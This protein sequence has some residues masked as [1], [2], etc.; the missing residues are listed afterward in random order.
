MKNCDAKLL[1]EFLIII[2]RF[3][4]YTYICMIFQNPAS[5]ILCSPLLSPSSSILPPS[6][7]FSCLSSPLFILFIKKTNVIY[8]HPSPSSRRGAGGKVVL[9]KLR[10]IKNH[11]IFHNY[12]IFKPIS[13]PPTPI[14]QPIILICQPIIVICQPIILICQPIILICQPIIVICQPVNRI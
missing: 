11:P 1:F 4:L 2:I 12:L 9:H 6:S 10:S 13:I 5:S 14:Y 7:R 3:I 8:S